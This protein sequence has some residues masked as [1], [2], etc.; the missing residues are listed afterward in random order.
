MLAVS[1]GHDDSGVGC[2]EIW[3]QAKWRGDAVV[4]GC[5]VKLKLWKGQDEEQLLIQCII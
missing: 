5:G 3:L 2:G 1:A 4:V